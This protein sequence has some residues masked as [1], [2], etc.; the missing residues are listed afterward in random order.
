MDA[1][2]IAAYAVFHFI[3]VNFIA[4]FPFFSETKVIFVKQLDYN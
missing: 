4:K 3:A 1:H 2:K